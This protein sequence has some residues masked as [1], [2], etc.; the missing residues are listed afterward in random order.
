MTAQV[1]DVQATTR[2]MRRL[3]LLHSIL[4]FWFYAGIL[5]L[6]INLVSGLI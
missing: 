1:S 5:A 3:V 4:S 6:A 2:S